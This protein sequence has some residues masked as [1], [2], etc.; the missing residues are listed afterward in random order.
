VTAANGPG[1]KGVIQA[2]TRILEHAAFLRTNGYDPDHAILRALT[3]HRP[4][5]ALE[6]VARAAWVLVVGS[7]DNGTSPTAPDGSDVYGGRA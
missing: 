7:N 1:P 3:K 5:L 2:L 6:C 4:G